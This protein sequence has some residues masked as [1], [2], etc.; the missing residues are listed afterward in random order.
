MVPDL[1]VVADATNGAQALDLL[2][3]GEAAVF[4]ARSLWPPRIIGE[5]SGCFY[6]LDVN[7]VEYL[8]SAGNYVVAHVGGNGFLTRATLKQM[9]ARLA[10]LGFVRIARPLLVNLRQ[11]AH[12]ERRDRGQYCFVMRGGARLVSSRDRHRELHAL[13]LSATV[14]QRL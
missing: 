7:E 5:K 1:E 8:A 12:V 10:P 2:E 6:F 9:A 4:S 13:L 14:P 3:A 11:L